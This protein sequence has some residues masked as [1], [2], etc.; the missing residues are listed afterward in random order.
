MVLATT[1]PPSC[2]CLRL[3]AAV[4]KYL[5][6]TKGYSMCSGPCHDSPFSNLWNVEQALHVGRCWLCR[7]VC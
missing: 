6:V 3:L 4:G 7:L 5:L 2:H 1:F